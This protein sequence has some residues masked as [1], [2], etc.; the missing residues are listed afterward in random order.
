MSKFGIHCAQNGGA[1]FPCVNGETYDLAGATNVSLPVWPS[2]LS[3]PSNDTF[4]KVE[5][6]V[7]CQPS[8]TTALYHPPGRVWNPKIGTN[9]LKFSA[10]SGVFKHGINHFELIGTEQFVAAGFGYIR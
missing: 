4:E 1:P 10:A 8:G 7:V 6:E 5:L 9:A 2:E 3:Y